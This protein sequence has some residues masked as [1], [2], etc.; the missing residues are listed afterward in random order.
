[1]SDDPFET[2]A[3]A[4]SQAQADVILS[5]FAWY[6]IPAYAKN[7]AHARADP[8]LTLALGGFPIRVHRDVAEEARALLEEAADR[9]HEAPPVQPLH[10]RIAKVAFLGV[11]GMTPQPRLSATIVR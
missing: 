3:I 5:M 2:V 4:Y 11:I 6:D 1:M 10:E 9:E 7:I 8:M